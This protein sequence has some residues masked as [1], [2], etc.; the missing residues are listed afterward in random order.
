MFKKVL[1][2]IIIVFIISLYIP[3]SFSLNGWDKTLTWTNGYP[4]EGFHSNKVENP[5]PIDFPKQANI[6]D[7]YTLL[8]SASPSISKLSSKDCYEKDFEQTISK[9]GSYRSLTNN[10][11]RQSPDHTLTL[12]H[13]LVSFYPNMN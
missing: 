8:D 2:S 9:T 13:E 3:R 1:L 10:Y 12:L 5:K 6:N 7:S 11:P 4:I